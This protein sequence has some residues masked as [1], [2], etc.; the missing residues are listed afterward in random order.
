MKFRFLFLIILIFFSSKLLSYELKISGIE[1]LSIDDLQTLTEID[2]KQKDFTSMDIDK[3]INDFYLNDL[4][5]DIDLSFNENVALLILSESKIVNN[6]FINNNTFIKDDF[7]IDQLLLKKGMLL[8]KNNLSNDI[9]NIVNLYKFRGYKNTQIN[10]SIESYSSDKVNLIYSIEEGKPSKI[11][12]IDFK[13]NKFFSDGYLNNII[14]SEKIGPFNIF[15]NSSN[16]DESIFEFD[17][18]KIANLYKVYGFIDV[19]VTYSLIEKNQNNFELSYYIEENER[20]K[21]SKI[22][23][24]TSQEKIFD[25][26]N[27]SINDLK[28]DLNKD[29]NFFNQKLVDK[30][31]DIIND[32]LKSKDILNYSFSYLLDI[33]Q[34]LISIN[35]IENKLDPIVINK[36][37]IFGNTITKDGT[38]RSKLSFEPGDLYNQLNIDQSIKKLNSYK[39]INNVEI[40]N[41]VESYNSNITIKIDEN[42]RTGNLMF[43]GSLS[44][45]TGFG[46][47]FTVKDYNF[48]GSGNEVNSSFN[49]NSESYLFDVSYKQYPL[50]A[51][52]ISNTYNI[53]NSED[54]LIDSFGFKSK[55]QGVGYGITY[56]YNEKTDIS[57]FIKYINENNHSAVNSNTA[58]TDNI[59][60]FQS[61]E[62]Q[63]NFK[64]DSTNDI[65]YPTSGTYNRLSIIYRPDEISDNSFYKLILKSNYFK[66]IERN[67]SFVYLSNNLGYAESL[68]G[69]L[70]TT[71]IFSLGGNN[72]K[73]FDYRGIGSFDNGIYL[74]GNKFF[75]STIGYG[76]NFIFDEKDNILMKLFYS[77]GSIW[78]SDYSN[79][80]FELRSSLGLSL[81]FKTAIPVT[82]SYSVPIMKNSSDKSRNFNFFLGTSF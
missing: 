64:L 59:G 51:S 7:I 47:A 20:F 4:I 30:Y 60:D 62:F 43:G 14:V 50:F 73:G 65:L 31:L 41:N 24:N 67:N 55:S 25:N 58:I 52:N 17:L 69:N 13:G 75:T 5:Y 45:D 34:N 54:D 22:N 36:V 74:G 38:I 21:I 1:K 48:L 12:K 68:N 27:S 53:F 16:F 76:D 57:A 49:I 42:N 8:N 72:F 2:L 15:K 9:E 78:D 44:G 56:E 61:F 11:V 66:P 18:N 6:I 81:D 33:K 80:D 40:D 77:I 46:L 82:M 35:F 32:E 37:D 29:D 28:K 23:F 19:N 26:V 71:N 63:L 39:Y 79:D 10:L 70:K 3:L